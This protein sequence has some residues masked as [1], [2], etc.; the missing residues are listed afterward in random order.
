MTALPSRCDVVVVGA[1]LAGLAAARGLHRAGLDVVVLESADDVGGR[2]RTDGVDGWRLDRGFQ[3]LNTAYPAVGRELDLARL[4]LRELTRGALVHV[5]RARH[6][7]ADPRRDPLG[8][9]RTAASPIGTPRDKV[10]L[11]ALAARVAVGGGRRLVAAEDRP[12]LEALRARGFSDRALD[13]FFR[14]FF[15]G[16]VLEDELSTSSRFVDLML[17]MFVRGRSAVP[18]RGMAEVPRQLAADLPAGGLHLSTPARSM[19]PTSVRTD[20]GSISARAVVCATDGSTARNFVPSLAAV[21][22]HSV[23][24]LYHVA[25][26]DPLGE[27][28]L[29]L[30]ADRSS[31]VVNTVVMT[32]AAP[33]YGPGDGRAL[34]ATSVL[35]TAADESLVRRRLGTLYGTGTADWEHLATCAV[36]RALPAMTA[37]HDLR[38]PVR[39]DGLYVC[40][41]HR[42][43]SSIQGALVSGRRAAA[44]VL[45][46]LGAARQAARK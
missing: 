10:L 7:Q 17:R 3:V 2:V 19:T 18:A 36:P 15:T 37:P 33:T 28:T 39:L 22:W 34:V 32:A 43:T 1:G 44:A 27:P 30:D 9:L 14:P 25:P 23:S 35:D 11:A 29:L 8:A 16:V 40:G 38:R 20:T 41:D 31:P 46:D 45:H 42:D 21:P 26:H 13:T 24:T 6:R 5:A 4:D 12:A